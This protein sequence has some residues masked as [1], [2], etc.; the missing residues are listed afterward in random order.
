MYA[1]LNRCRKSCRLRWLNYLKPDIK[2]GDFSS[3]EVDLMIRLHKLLGNRWS[4]IAGRLPGRTAN[5][6]KNY[7]NTHMLKKTVATRAT[8]A[9]KVKLANSDSNGNIISSNTTTSRPFKPRPRS[10]WKQTYDKN[11]QKKK[12]D[13]GV[14]EGIGRKLGAAGGTPLRQDSPPSSTTSSLQTDKNGINCD[15]EG[16]IKYWW[17]NLI[18][19]DDPENDPYY[20]Y[21][22]NDN[23]ICPSSFG[24]VSGAGPE[25]IPDNDFS[26]SLMSCPDPQGYLSS[27]FVE[28]EEVV[29][30]EGG[31][32][33]A[34]NSAAFLR[35]DEEEEANI[36]GSSY[37]SSGLFS[38]D[39]DFWGLL[40]STTATDHQFHQPAAALVL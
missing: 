29:V 24:G 31:A 6:V 3:E 4:L 9:E 23:N 13:L 35:G 30:E 37:C 36:I 11:N 22:D 38:P 12:D 7:W 40:L 2:R 20:F 27:K 8:G 26:T 15:G 14:I 18:D 25:S 19:L 1:G 33:A 16:G 21:D 28:G 32:A 34:S 39:S 5:D 10:F 17:D